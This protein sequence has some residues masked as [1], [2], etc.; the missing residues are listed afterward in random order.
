MK[1]SREERL[2]QAF[3]LTESDLK[4]L[5]YHLRKWVTSLSFRIT[6]KDNLNREFLTLDEFLRFENLPK[7]N[8]LS[9]RIQGNSRDPSVS[10]SATFTD[11]VS[12]NINI[13]IEGDEV[14]VVSLSDLFEE[15]LAGIRPW[16]SSLARANFY[17]I[18]YAIFLIPALILMLL[19][20]FGMIKVI[21]DSPSLSMTTAIKIII[22][23]MFFGLLP[24][25]VGFLLHKIQRPIFP[26][27]VFA[28]GQGAKRHRDKEMMRTVV[29]LGF[30]I[31]LLASILVT[32]LFSH[33]S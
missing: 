10:L 13:S 26:M 8:I 11:D 18:I 23:G 20:G 21:E 29:V 15:T 28:L 6:S 2:T 31:S 27:G 7:R 24:P 9:L 25:F 16:Y 4:K 33:W 30:L 32:L 14:A 17:V 3:V 19:I 12:R 22:K 5:H 1:T